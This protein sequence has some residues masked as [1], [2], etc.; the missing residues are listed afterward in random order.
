MQQL[1]RATKSSPTRRPA[2]PPAP[3]PAPTPPTPAPPTTPP[4]A[5]APPDPDQ[6]DAFRAMTWIEEAV[7]AVHDGLVQ[8]AALAGH[9]LNAHQILLLGA[10]DVES[11]AKDLEAGGRTP[12]SNLSYTVN[13]LLEPQA[14][15][16][17][18]RPVPMD[19]RA[20]LLK[21]TAKGDQV[22]AIARAKLPGLLHAH[23]LGALMDA[24]P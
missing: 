5:A 19:K 11:T 2:A 8:A 18:S 22:A 4:P 20:I 24:A 1:D 15:Y 14:G 23:G 17:S 10:L 9:R 16:L 21:R 13:K 6:V 3:T 12:L 7:A